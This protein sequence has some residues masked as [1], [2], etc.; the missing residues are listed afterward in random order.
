MK[1]FAIAVFVALSLA[2]IGVVHAQ[3][4]VCDGPLASLLPQC[5]G[6][7]PP[8]PPAPPAG[9]AGAAIVEISL[10]DDD[11]RRGYLLTVRGSGFNSGAIAGVYVLNR[12]PTSGAECADIIR[13]GVNVA[14][15]LV[16][17][18]GNMAVTFEVTVPTFMPGLDNYLC[19]VDGEGR[20][21]STD[22]EQFK[23]EPSIR[24]VPA[25][26]AAG[27]IV[28]VFAQDY[29]MDGAPFEGILVA[30]QSVDPS[31][32]PTG[33]GG[34]HSGSASFAVPGGLEGTL[35]VDATWGGVKEDAKITIAPSVLNLSKEEISANESITIRGS[36][37]GDGAGCLTSITMSGVELMLISDD[38]VSGAGCRDVEVSSA[39]QFAA[40]VA[41]WPEE[42]N[43]DNPALTAGTH[44]IEVV[45]DEGFTGSATITIKEPTLTIT[46]DVAGPRD[47]ITISGENWPVEN[48]DGGNIDEVVIDID[49]G[50]DDEDAEPDASGS[51][52]INYRVPNDVVIPS[53]VP[54]KASY[55][56]ASEIAKIAKIAAFSVPATARRIVE[57]APPVPSKAITLSASG[58]S[59]S[60][61]GVAVS[62]NE[63]VTL[64]GNGFGGGAGCLVSATI[65][66]SPLLLISSDDVPD[67]LN[68]QRCI[69][70]GVDSTGRFSATVAI[71]PEDDIGP[72]P[73]LF[74]GTQTIEVEDDQ[75]FT[76]AASI[77]IKEPTLTISPN[78]AGPVDYIT[79]SGENW[80]VENEYGGRID[81]V[82][83]DI[84]TGFDDDEVDPD[85]SGRWSI[86]YRVPNDVVIP[87]TVPVKA[88]YGYGSEIV[89]VSSFSVPQASLMPEPARTVPGDIITLSG[90]G[91]SL[92][93]TDIAVKLGSLIVH[94]PDG[95]YTDGEGTMNGLEIMIPYLE[96]G[97]YTVQIIVRDTVAFGEL[98]IS[99]F[100]T[101]PNGE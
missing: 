26:V 29:P 19:V 32:N 9:D 91:F 33:I 3:S 10:S 100:G 73:A 38:G 15:A 78:V 67:T 69:D 61:P 25:T 54:V 35:R 57:P 89:K 1:S 39:G 77:T 93:E 60:E 71:W 52:S 80:P 20:A 56:R 76:A 84:D 12:Q 8:P 72:N 86:T 96:P 37:F 42:R 36:G 53:T 34:D 48:D 6:G 98:E 5:Q 44:T 13:D 21:S 41:V 95:A 66:G 101:T 23:L 45:D 82:K 59:P 27:D 85:S 47:Y 74:T 64:Q 31:G 14:S 62:A 30:G 43:A 16:D 24:V 49:S 46:P 83:V 50:A 55:G 17:M 4:D 63:S 28:N 81:E 97:S 51:W 90:T 58:F 70:V 88:T 18:N 75:G 94:V 2:I 92:F 40:T 22:M 11:N 79:I 68:G 87:S 99:A 65:S 7:A